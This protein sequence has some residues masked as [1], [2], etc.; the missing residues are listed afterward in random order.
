MKKPPEEESPSSLIDAR[1][2]AIGGWKGETLARV[3]RLIS[4]A[5]PDVVEAVKWRKPSNPAGVPVFE[6]DGIICTAD[7]FKSYVK[8]TFA[9]GA[10]LDDPSNVFN[11]G[12]GGNAMRAVNLPEGAELD[13]AAFKKLVRAAVDLNRAKANAKKT[14]G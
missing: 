5:D 12:L 8:V 2:E 7:A 9:K 3:R 13:E 1:I 11:A 6:H 14:A 10:L 4:E